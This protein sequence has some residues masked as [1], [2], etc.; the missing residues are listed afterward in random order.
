MTSLEDTT[1]QHYIYFYD[2]KYVEEMRV[3]G[4]DPHLDIAVQAGMLTAAQVEAHKQGTENHSD[5]RKDAKQVNFSAVYGVGPPKLSI[6]T[7]WPL[8]KSKAMLETYWE[9]NKA[10]KQIAADC[11][12]RVFHKNG[13]ILDYVVGTITDNKRSHI[14]AFMNSIQEMWLYNPVSKFWYSLRYLK[15]TFSTLNQGTGVYCFD[16]QVFHVRK[17]GIRLSLQ[18]HDELGFMLREEDKEE[19]QK[20]LEI[21]IDKTNRALNLNV[22]LGISVDFGHN[23]ADC[24]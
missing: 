18:Y 1:K 6:S 24:H 13:S 8:E 17:Q 11:T 16:T 10:V 14:D 2:P 5:I 12:V 19:V 3:P 22:P 20:R 15:D 21:A 7:G 9:R 23:Y 4:F